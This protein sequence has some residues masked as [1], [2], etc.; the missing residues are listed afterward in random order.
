MTASNATTRSTAGPGYAFEDQVAADLLSRF[1]LDMPIP[2]I[3]VPGVQL[4]SQVRA[5]GLPIDDLLCIG[6]DGDG[7]KHKLALSC[8]S[9]MQ[10]TANGL[11]SDFITAAWAMWRDRNRISPKTDAMALV[12]RGRHQAFDPIWADI[13]NWSAA[14]DVE[15]ALA[16]IR[17]S[18][19]HQ[20]VFDSVCRPGA[21]DG[22]PPSAEETLALIARLAVLPVD[23]Q[24]QT[25]ETLA[26]ALHRCR[27][28]LASENL[29]EAEKLWGALVQR[30]EDARLGNGT[31][32]LVGLLDD[33][34]NRFVLK[35]HPSVAAAWKKLRAVSDDHLMKIG[36]SLP[37]G[38]VVARQEGTGI[39]QALKD[40]P[41]C[42]VTGDSGVGKSAMVRQILDR[43]FADETQLWMDPAVLRSLLSEADRPVLG[44]DQ[45]LMTILERCPSDHILI[46]D[47]AERLD[48]TTL[49]R[50]NE[51]LA[52]IGHGQHS[53]RGSV[54]TRIVITTQ[55]V[56]GND[57]FKGTPLVAGIPRITISGLS[58]ESVQEALLSVPQLRW[59]AG[60]VQVMPVLAN[61]R[62][63]GWV[64]A[65][66]SS[67]TEGDAG[68]L[69]SVTAVADRLWLRWTGGRAT[70]KR[71]LIRL[72]ERDAAFERSF[73]ISRLDASD[74]DAFDG[75]PPEAPLI[76]NQR[77]R[78]EFQHDL[79][80]DWARYQ[81]LKE[82][83]DD[84]GAWSALAP[85]PLWMPALRLFGQ[86]LLRQPDQSR[87]GWDHALSLISV[88]ANDAA[89]DLLLDALCLDPQL[90]AHLTAR[91][92]LF[93]GN[94]ASL[95][96]RLLHRFTHLATTPSVPDSAAID[97]ALRIYLE[98]EMRTPIFVRW[99]PM[100]R[101]LAAHLERIAALASPAV[102][103]LCLLWLSRTPVMAGARQVP[104]RGTLARLA[105]MTAQAEQAA[106]I[107]HPHYGGNGE[108]EQSI[109]IAALAGAA[110]IPLEVVTFA[111]E[112]AQRRPLSEA[113]WARVHG[114]QTA[115]RARRET[116][117]VPDN[118]AARRRTLLPAITFSR[119]DLPPWPLGATS[120][121]N[122]AFRE[123]V[124]RKQAL[125]QL[126][127][128]A[129][130]VVSEVLLASIIDDRPV[131]DH[132]GSGFDAA[133]GVVYDHHSYPTIFWKS[134]FLLFLSHD[135]EA[136]LSS[137]QK[138]LDFAM[139]RWAERF[140]ADV[141][142]PALAIQLG[143]HRCGSFR[144]THWHFRWSR[145]NSTANGQLFCALDAVERW[146]VLKIEAGED[147]SR[148]CARLID[149]QSSTALLGILVT[150]GKR[151]PS[152]FR[153][154][155]A[156]L[157][158]VEE[159]YLWDD[160]RV[161]LASIGFDLAH[162]SRQGE[163]AFNL[164]RDWV[165]APY[166]T[167]RLRFVVTE[168]V[169]DDPVLANRILDAAARWPSPYDEK[170]GLERRLMLASFD[171]AN[172]RRH[173]EQES[174]ESSVTIVFPNALQR[175]VLAFHRSAGV[176][177]Q[178]LT[179]PG[180]CEK[181]IAA[182][183][184]LSSE[185]ADYLAGVIPPVGTPL[186]DEGDRR[187]MVAA[188]AAALIAKAGPWAAAHQGAMRN[189][190][191][192]IRAVVD[193][194]GDCRGE[195][196][197]VGL[198]D[199][200]A[201][202]FAAVGALHAS[203]DANSIEPWDSAVLAIMTSGDLSAIGVLMREAWR[204]R[205]R[206]GG[207]WC[208][209]NQMVVWAAGLDKLAPRYDE[210]DS[211]GPIWNRWL[212]RFRSS[213]V[214]G[215]SV[216][217]SG[218]DPVDIDAR[219][220][221]LLARRHARQVSREPM[222]YRGSPRRNN[223][224]SSHYLNAGFAWLLEPERASETVQD[225][226]ARMLVSRLWAWESLRMGGKVDDEGESDGEYD[227]PSDLGYAILHIFPQVIMAEQE[228][229]SPAQ[230]RAILDLGPAGHYAVDQ[231]LSC[232]FLLLFSDPHPGR[233]VLEWKAMLD[234]AF[235]ANWHSGRRGYRGRTLITHLLGLNASREISHSIAVVQ[236]LPELL[237]FYTQW[238]TTQL[239]RD[240]DNIVAF[241]HFLTTEPGRFLR[242]QGVVW[243]RQA[244]PEAG[245]FY[246]SNTGDYIA[247]VLDTLL[248]HHS[249]EV[250]GS[251]ECLDAMI[252]IASLLVRSQVA[253]AMGLQGRIA[254]LR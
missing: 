178:P 64:I 138:L 17:Q 141:R 65:E 147:I 22:M 34:R 15:L 40:G 2:A 74:V 249:G 119:E 180:E 81:R 195:L 42:V 91:V 192:I 227:T 57:P 211:V 165:F 47:S 193:E 215:R 234:F 97:P 242:M 56:D 189:A 216:V 154:V 226:E 113:G 101:F 3:D 54:R 220:D 13:K 127:L 98:V 90:D 115:E 252:A 49:S 173:A 163:A 79:A 122:V 169:S 116:G 124:L 203:F 137:L 28:A 184:L 176:D 21:V 32:T 254:A 59:V 156:P 157:L 143:E 205:D 70:M 253:T 7:G 100:V 155:L 60:D 30:A 158:E 139:D 105:L 142:V 68:A 208:S 206:L 150:L 166:R 162:F 88:G 132:G 76:L 1:L 240:E 212:A 130:E 24:L 16:R 118:T 237:P 78:I 198:D 33:I 223:G 106:G 44:I 210:E 204:N 99:P 95:L 188:A 199:A 73:A 120:R 129:P 63:L 83:A 183:G 247:E 18:A 104:F 9:N 5:L 121:V 236:R 53:D 246:R 196:R 181:I 27:M 96:L 251:P 38:H 209:I 145:E 128:V 241:S 179:L 66:A 235:A 109:F 238:A 146:L 58:D 133:L 94:K 107:A 221:R 62:A 160:H 110:D 12:T 194:I 8:K 182:K 126:M 103:K 114:L 77:G 134:P 20:R 171:P 218:V 140:P 152:L 177:L 23:F 232:W 69:A 19:A 217:L 67:F 80:S 167:S 250:V 45:P 164:A 87:D 85:H 61:L 172:L 4:L 243:L 151:Q 10:V 222:S 71:L 207:D 123:V 51:L 111:L 89:V 37:N 245:G 159:L 43:D 190:H 228:Q 75:R 214:F 55:F 29:A 200:A 149:M 239:V 14:G 52:A 131:R 229:D 202:R 197:V 117:S 161:D 25:S 153:G 187:E 82:M 6:T 144:G 175:E 213:N 170:S 185:V 11:P 225:P 41:G 191:R 26:A 230:W 168:L 231:F 224:L 186:P 92:E 35:A 39:T 93:F 148:W 112:M 108:R 233:F 244:L 219:I 102:S 86:F 136:A 50:L 201:L 84:V 48:T 72:A 174:G 31:I 36:G 248:V 46:V 125:S 135:P